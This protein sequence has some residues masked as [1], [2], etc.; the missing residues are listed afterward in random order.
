MK[1][2]HLLPG[3]FYILYS[4]VIFVYDKIILNKYYFY[5]D[6]IDKDFD[7]WYQIAGL[8]SMVFYFALSIRYYSLYKRLIVQLTSFAD[9]ILFRW[10][11]NFLFAFLAMQ[12]LQVIFLPHRLYLSYNFNLCGWMVVLFVIFYYNVL[13]SYCR[14]C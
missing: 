3:I 14:I 7:Q 13:H 5:E 1:S 11:K 8:L 9:T 10:A 6:G 12:M 4:I 2:L